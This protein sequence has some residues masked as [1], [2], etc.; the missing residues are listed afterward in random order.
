MIIEYLN[1]YNFPYHQLRIDYLNMSDLL[2]NIKSYYT[3]NY[4]GSM[5]YHTNLQ[6]FHLV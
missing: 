4:R 5:A 1:Y 6:Y 2:T 3:L